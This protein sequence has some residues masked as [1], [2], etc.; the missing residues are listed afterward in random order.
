VF[1]IML[2]NLRREAGI[3]AGSAQ[4]ALAALAATAFIALVVRGIL[5]ISWRVASIRSDFG[6]AEYVGRRLFSVYY[7]PFEMISL[8]LLVAMAGAVILAKKRL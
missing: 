6:T 1:V 3:K 5:P 8:V 7:Y 2:L 4:R